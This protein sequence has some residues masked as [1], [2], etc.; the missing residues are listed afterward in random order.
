MTR[1]RPL[2]DE[3][4]AIELR[5]DAP[6]DP[7]WQIS[8]PAAL[9]RD[10]AAGRLHVEMIAGQAELAS[11]DPRGAGGHAGGGRSC[12]GAAPRDPGDARDPRPSCCE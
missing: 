7:A 2:L 1:L 6:I 4:N 5:F 11:G 12:A 9:R 10:A 3:A 8:Q